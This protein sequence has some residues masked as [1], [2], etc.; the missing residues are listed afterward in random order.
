MR[1]TSGKV[2]SGKIIVEDD[3]LPEGAT[4]TVVAPEDSEE[5]ELGPADEAAL[6]EAIEQADDGD[7]VST[8]EVLSRLKPER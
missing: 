6:H 2:V 1:I 3:V 8:S 7:V 5:F 4:V